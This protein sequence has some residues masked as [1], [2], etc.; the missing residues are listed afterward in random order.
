MI[1]LSAAFSILPGLEIIISLSVLQ[2]IPAMSHISPKVLE[3]DWDVEGLQNIL[4]ESYGA[5]I[6]L[7]GIIDEG[8]D[9]DEI[10]ALIQVMLIG[11]LELHD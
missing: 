10:L 7:Q 5:D 11:F 1:S 3:D 2:G 4:K 8:L 6:P 9:V